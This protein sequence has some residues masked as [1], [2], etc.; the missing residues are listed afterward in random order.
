MEPNSA[1]DSPTKDL[2]SVV[3]PVYNRTVELERAIRSAL[4]QTW[5]KFE[6]IVVDDGSD[7]DIQ[8]VCHSFSDKR[9]RYIRCNQ[10]KNANIARNIGIMVAQGEYIAMLDSDDEFLRHHL[11]RRLNKI[12]E[13]GCDGI[14]G[15]VYFF[16]DNQKTALRLS[17]PRLENELMVNYLLSDGFAQT[18]SHFYRTAAVLEIMW[19]ETLTRHQDYDFSVRFADKFIFLPDYEPTVNFFF[20]SFSRRND[21]N[22]DSCIEFIRRYEDQIAPQIYNDYHRRLYFTFR[23]HSN[24][25]YV[26]HYARNSYRYIHLVSF[27]DF[28]AVHPVRRA[29]IWAVFLK[30]IWLHVYYFAKKWLRRMAQRA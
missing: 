10:H 21:I 5:Q 20:S 15:S 16:V 4:N 18:S 6:I 22:L 26:R 2:I 9:I 8:V 12:K 29:L 14:F 13:W 19:D 1:Q 3:I 30:F 27:G 11:E 17:R 28:L 25:A 7:V 24:R 23:E